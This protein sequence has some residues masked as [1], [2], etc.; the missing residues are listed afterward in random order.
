MKRAKSKICDLDG[1]KNPKKLKER[2]CPLHYR[3]AT[4]D[5]FLS[6]LYSKMSRRVRGLK[7]ATKRPDIYTGLTILPKDAFYNWAKNH[8]D[9]LN[10]Y[11]SWVSN[12]FDRKLTPSVNRMNSKKGYILGNIEWMTTSQNCG[13]AA[14]V[15]TMK[16]KK[17]IYELLGVINGKS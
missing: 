6:A 1:C 15:R 2:F 12:D 10:L 4:I 11:K 3:N 17:A 13:L 16:Q 14:G 9:F 8:S 7:G 5:K